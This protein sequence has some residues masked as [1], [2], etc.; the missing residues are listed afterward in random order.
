MQPETLAFDRR[1]AL[2]TT[3]G[4]VAG[5]AATLTAISLTSDSVSASVDG[6][7]SIDST[8]TEDD[9]I[10]ELILSVDAQF[11]WEGTD[12]VE[13]YAVTLEAKQPGVDWELIDY[14]F[15]NSG[16]APEGSGETTLSGDLLGDVVAESELSDG[17]TIDLNARLEFYLEDNGDTLA[18]D[19][20][21]DEFAL[22]IDGGDVVM[23]ATVSGE[24]GL[25][26]K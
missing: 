9:D 10:S 15:S 1:S 14:E 13:S 4:L 22:T 19:S 11:E 26:V 25:T 8:T 23:D 17:E 5:S 7:L 20:H 12:S 16:I 3:A 24:G 6:G 18:S 21:T 2:K